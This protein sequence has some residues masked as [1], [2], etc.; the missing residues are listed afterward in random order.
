MGCRGDREEH[1]VDNRG[2]LGAELDIPEVAIGEE[3]FGTGAELLVE[4]LLGN[5]PRLWI[6]ACSIKTDLL[7][8]IEVVA[9]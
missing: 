2:D 4:T 5:D 3:R 8:G 9:P 1:Q 7:Q 6:L